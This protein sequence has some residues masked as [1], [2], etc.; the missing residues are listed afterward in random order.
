MNPK[1]LT[2]LG[3]A[4]DATPEQ[5]AAAVAA[6]KAKADDAEGNLAALKSSTVPMATMQELQG[7]VA[8]L[9]AD[10]QA[11]DI[12]DLVKPALADGRLLPAMEPW[13]RDLGTTHLAALKQYL[14]TAPVI[15][16]LTGTQSEGRAPNTAGAKL[17]DEEM[18]ACTMLGQSP[19]EYLAFK[20]GLKKE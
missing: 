17:T 14:D 4:E 19:D 10:K 6:L 3:L 1:T 7:H 15:A 12:D 8:A 5:I 13:A 11:R 2:L 16:A 20:A 18:A 9:T